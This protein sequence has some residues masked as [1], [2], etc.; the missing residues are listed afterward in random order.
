MLHSIGA[1]DD[2]FATVG[3]RQVGRQ[4]THG[5]ATGFDVNFIRHILQGSHHDVGIVTA[6]EVVGMCIA[7]CQCID[8]KSPVTDALRCRKGYN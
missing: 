2:V 6:A 7:S 5:G 3:S 8:D 1:G 4:E